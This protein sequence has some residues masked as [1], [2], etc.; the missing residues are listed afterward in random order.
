LIADVLSLRYRTLKSFNNYPSRVALPLSLLRLGRGYQRAVVEIGP[1]RPG[2]TALLSDI[3]LPHV[4]VVTNTLRLD[5]ASTDE[6]VVEEQAG[7]V[8]ALPSAMQGALVLNA[9]DALSRRLGELSPIQPVYYGLDPTAHLWADEVESMGLEGIRFRLHFRQEILHVR[10]PL[11]G[12]YSVHTALSAAAVGLAEGLTWT[13][14]ASGLRAS[15]SQLRLVAVRTQSGALILD[16][17]YSASAESTLA[18]LNLLGE[19]QGRHIAVLGDLLEPGQ[20]DEIG[21]QKV[22][23]RAAE[24]A[25]HLIAVGERSK[26]ILDSARR[27]GFRSNQVT[28]VSEAMQAVEVLR[29]ILKEGDV[30]LVKGSQNLQLERIT[31]ALEVSE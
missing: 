4:G 21:S 11:L 12:H 29:T 7:L 6:S 2:E 17:S 9:D 10:V 27:A 18:S 23:A 25:Q 26:S 5:E 3:A 15:P 24:V 13:E 31:N 19:M 22:G 14:I 28:W 20:S 1:T 16:D 30:V 8:R